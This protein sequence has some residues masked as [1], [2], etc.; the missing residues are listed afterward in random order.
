VTNQG[1]NAVV[2]DAFKNNP[3]P[4]LFTLDE[5]LYAN[6]GEPPSPL[7]SLGEPLSLPIKSL[8]TSAT[9]P[10]YIIIPVKEVKLK[11]KK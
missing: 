8:N 11:K 2:K 5:T 7:T 6:L 3:S 4:G 10:H 9:T 1:N